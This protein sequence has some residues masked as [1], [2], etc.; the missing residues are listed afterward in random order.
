M[1]MFQTKLW[2][3]S[4][5]LSGKY[6]PKSSHTQHFLL[7]LLNKQNKLSPK[8]RALPKK[9]FPSK[10]LLITKKFLIHSVYYLPIT[11]NLIPSS[12]LSVWKY[13]FCCLYSLLFGKSFYY[14]HH[15]HLNINICLLAMNI[16]IIS[17]ICVEKEMNEAVYW[18]VKK[19][20]REKNNQKK[21][22]KRE[23]KILILFYFIGN[24]TW[25]NL[26]INIHPFQLSAS[27]LTFSLSLSICCESQNGQKKS[28]YKT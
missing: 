5:L 27:P 6:L 9:K 1:I 22:Q 8:P 23:K 25:L 17:S 4:T 2:L 13:A 15:T 7:I 21:K 12:S 18:R 28:W 19:E 14:M 24:M 3:I 11:L 16:D 20:R 10:F 26:F